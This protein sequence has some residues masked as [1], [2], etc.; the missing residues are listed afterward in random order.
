MVIAHMKCAVLR[1]TVRHEECATEYDGAVVALA[2]SE[3]QS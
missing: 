1:L 2:E 3:V